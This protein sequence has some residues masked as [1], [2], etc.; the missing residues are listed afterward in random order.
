[1][2]AARAREYSP[3]VDRADVQRAVRSSAGPFSKAATPPPA[4]LAPGS[5]SV[6][7]C[8][9]GSCLCGGGACAG[10]CGT[11][12]VQNRAVIV[13]QG[14]PASSQHQPPIRVRVA[15][16][17]S[18]SRERRQPVDHLRATATAPHRYPVLSAVSPACAHASF[19]SVI[20][21]SRSCFERDCGD[22]WDKA[23]KRSIASVFP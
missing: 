8:W 15:A 2:A 14:G 18:S 17:S 23:A 21:V 19:D 10:R 1:M 13:I 4:E 6:Y 20:I 11:H 3:Y 5:T 22:G 9:F 7:R 12:H 16:P